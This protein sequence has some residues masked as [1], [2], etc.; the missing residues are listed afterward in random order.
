M[1]SSLGSFSGL[2]TFQKNLKLHKS[3]AV[4]LKELKDILSYEPAYLQNARIKSR[5]PTRKY[6]VHGWAKIFQADLTY[7]KE[8]NGFLYFFL[9]IDVRKPVI[10]STCTIINLFTGLYTIHSHKSPKRVTQLSSALS[11]YFISMG[12]RRLSRQTMVIPVF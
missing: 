9:L 1:N 4:S 10:Y 12:S 7:M 5:F 11:K 8:S 6:H 3:I 2:V